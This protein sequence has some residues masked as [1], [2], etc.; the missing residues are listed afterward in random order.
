MIKLIALFL[1]VFTTTSTLAMTDLEIE[2]R[3]DA[4][5]AAELDFYEAWPTA[6]LVSSEVENVIVMDRMYT[7]E[8]M[9]EGYLPDPY[10]KT[11]SSLYSVEYEIVNDECVTSD[12]ILVEEYDIAD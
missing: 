3:N 6:E 5:F 7:L 11:A 2:C 9:V 4:Q 1:T 8:V 10:N 12:P